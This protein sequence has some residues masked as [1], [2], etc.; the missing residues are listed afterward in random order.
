MAEI[1]VQFK[2]KINGYDKAEVNQ[3]VQDA[4]AK[5]QERALALATLQQR[6]VELE[7]RLT[8]ITGDDE[9]V[10]EKLELYDK[11]MKKM[12]GDY[13]NLLAPA[14]AKAKAIEEKAQREYEIRM[15][16]A[17]CTAEGIYAE[18][19][20]R[21]A[22]VVDANMDRLYALLDQFIYSKTL[23]GRFDAFIKDCKTISAKISAA[24]ST[25]KQLPKKAYDKI[26][27]GV[28]N[29]YAIAKE[30]VAATVE[31]YKEAVAAAEAEAEVVEAEAEAPVVE[32]EAAEVAV[33]AAE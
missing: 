7:A 15:D 1:T 10:E 5:L 11:L 24:A 9:S 3:F 27:V 14:V 6:V 2:N 22:G 18:T 28:Q 30:K 26:K 20:D 32:V 23:A 12:D 31:S 13:N 29:T 19:A 8:K 21:I 16:Q 17:R 33:E 4:E 25:A